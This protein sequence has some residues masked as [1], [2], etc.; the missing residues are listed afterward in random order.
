M[1]LVNIDPEVIHLELANSE[2]KKGYNYAKISFITTKLNVNYTK[3]KLLPFL[4]SNL[5]TVLSM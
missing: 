2:R 3:S 4:N 5:V 1:P